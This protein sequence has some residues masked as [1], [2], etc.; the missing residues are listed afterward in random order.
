[1]AVAEVYPMLQRRRHALA[2]VL[3]GAG[4]IAMQA[5]RV[6]AAAALHAA[7]R[8]SIA[9]LT[10]TGQAAMHFCASTVSS[11]RLCAGYN[12]GLP[13]GTL[14]AIVPGAGIGVKGGVGGV[15]GTIYPG[16]VG[17]T[18]G[19]GLAR[20]VESV[21]A[22]GFDLKYAYKLIPSTYPSGSLLSQ[23]PRRS[24]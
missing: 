18:G 12:I 21:A 7:Y 14:G 19:H 23:L 9:A 22:N 16:P 15:A 11:H 17:L 24:W 20:P 8:A 10:V 1:M 5:L 13:P 6:K 4:Q 3:P 2:P